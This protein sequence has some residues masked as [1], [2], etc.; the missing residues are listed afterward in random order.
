MDGRS[1][2]HMDDDA[3]TPEGTI[4]S[5]APRAVLKHTRASRWMHWI[6]FP[7]IFIMIWSGLRIYWANDVYRIG[8]G[9][10]TLVEFFPQ[11]VY[12]F[13]QLDRKLAKGLAFHL[14][15]GWLFAIN[16][17]AFGAYLVVTGRWRHIFPERGWLRDSLRVVAH[18]LKLTK[19]APPSQSFY[20]AAQRVTYTLVILLGALALITGFAIFKPTQLS[21]LTSLLGGYE[22]ARA[23][24]FWTTMSFLAFFGIHILQ[25]VRAGWSNFASMITGYELKRPDH[26]ASEID[27]VPGED[28]SPESMDDLEFPDTHE[29]V[30][31]DA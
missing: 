8:W 23:I 10:W 7:L 31:T 21:P 1:L 13:F 6:N 17:V 5:E 30:S 24:H 9:D 3:A 26:G 20:N 29:E 27:H 28:D 16:G 19:Q 2:D 18:D 22:N 25:V 12:D 14:T 11:W 4:E 15:F